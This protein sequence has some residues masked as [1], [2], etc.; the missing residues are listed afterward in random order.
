MK[1]LIVLIVSIALCFALLPGCS[2]SDMGLGVT[3]GSDENRENIIHCVGS[4][5]EGG[6]KVVDYFGDETVL[7]QPPQRVAVV[8][9]TPLNIWYDLGG[10]SVCTS[11]I[12]DGNIKLVKEHAEEMLNLPVVGAVYALDMEA[13]V[14][15]DPDLII[16][17]A[18]VQTEATAALREMGYPVISV[19]P[20]S[21]QDVVELYQAFGSIL[22]KED[23]AAQ[24]VD[25]LTTERNTY[26]EKAPKDGKSVVILYLTASALS[27]K[28][29]NSI[30]G[31][32]A[33]SLHIRN[34][35]S[36]LPPDSIGS[37]TTPLDIEYI[38]QQNPDMI[39]VT[40]MIGSN[41]LA[42]ET[43]EKH[44]AQNQ[45]WQT[46]PAVA[47]GQVYYLPQDYFL[48]NAGPYYD[49]GIHYMACTVYPEIFG[50]V[51]TWYAE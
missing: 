5:D 41:E 7:E 45:A 31:E 17:Q 19:L 46:V 38:V 39:L 25:R 13:V 22:G 34:I 28:L 18:G 9:G 36:N 10:K 37:E 40:S 15:Q 8:S 20:R 32:V 47:A 3:N 1:K 29:D 43:M 24:R 2:S 33:N 21:F 51:S 50:E 35:A 26:I 6:L 42:V 16:T 14:A 44:F 4:Y 12:A 11:N 49:E 30:A 27:V 48:Y 23:V